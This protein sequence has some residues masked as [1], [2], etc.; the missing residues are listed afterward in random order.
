MSAHDKKVSIFEKLGKKG[1][2][3]LSHISPT[4]ASRLLYRA[5]TKKRLNLKNPKL[6]NEKI[7]KLKLNDYTNN[8]L[9]I[10]CTDKYLVRDFV[11]EKGLP[12]IL[13]EIYGVYD[14]AEDIEWDKLPEK[15]VLKCNHG[16]GYNIICTDKNKLN[17]LKATDTLNKWLNETFGY[18]T[19]ELHYTK[20]KPLI[21]CEKYIETSGGVF[22]NDYKIYCFD[23]EPKVI[24]TCTDRDKNLRLNFFDLNWNELQYMGT[25]ADRA[26]NPPQKPK[27][28]EEMIEYAKILSKPFKYV[29]VDFYDLNGKPL[30]GELTFTPAR[31]AAWYYSDDGNKQLGDMLKL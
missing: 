25:I 27:C 2:A 14:R 8:E 21:L 26:I 17:T 23:G 28:L 4:L 13:N 7:M 16:C 1:I 19:A 15:F 22:P 31:C 9:V 3:V 6:F 11:K 5:I 12:N 20:I 18:E 29:R 30:F 24:L 10:K